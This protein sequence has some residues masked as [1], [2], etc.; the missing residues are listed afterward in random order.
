NTV[1]PRFTAV[2]PDTHYSD[3]TGFGWLSAGEREAVA[4]PLTPYLEVRAAAKN[5]GNLPHDLLFRNYIRG[6]GA[7]TFGVKVEPGEYKVSLLHPDRTSQ[8]LNLRA[9]NGRLTIPMP[10]GEWSVSGI[11]VKGT[12]PAPVYPPPLVSAAVP[13][14]VL[15]HEAP[16]D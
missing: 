7:Q 15:R 16:S 12:K 1:E 3:E 11:V 4:I 5:P 13:R 8:E 9:E 6:K 14:P 10:A 2:D